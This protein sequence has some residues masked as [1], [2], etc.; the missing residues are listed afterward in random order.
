[1]K[2]IGLLATGD[3]II[4]GDILNTN[5]QNI[6]QSLF[7]N[8]MQIGLHMTASDIQ[9]DIEKSLIFLLKDH[10]AVILTGGL[11]PTSDD[12]TRFALASAI[13]QELIFS[14]ES[15][16]R[17]QQ[18]F[19]KIKLQYQPESN[20]QQCLFPEQAEIFANKNGT[21][22]ACYV[23]ANGKAIF[24]LP[25]PP[26]E[27]LPIFEECVIPKLQQLEFASGQFHRN[28]LLLGVSEGAIAESLDNI[29][30]DYDVS[31]GFRASMPY[32]EFKVHS[33]SMDEIERFYQQAK[34]VIDDKHVNKENY[35]ASL[36]L[37]K[38]LQ[39]NRFNIHIHDEATKG[40][41]LSH[42]LSP[43]TQPHLKASEHDAQHAFL[44]KGLDEIWQQSNVEQTLLHV[45]E[46]NTILANRG[47]RTMRLAFE[48][49]SQHI[50]NT[51]DKGK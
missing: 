1:M 12:R 50:L 32:V 29:A 42:I 22:D 2:T 7:S 14:D 13:Q 8:G 49:I 48:Y 24:M 11:G 16:Q 6:A 3:E 26:H 45:N 34:S 46:C 47:M 15:W 19:T 20:K 28:W 17:I 27:C 41:Y 35:P 10:D 43:E 51:I 37:C 31:T 25:G 23:N 9:T 30:K 44:I 21:A 18:R 5:T 40:L 38:Q 33:E 36:L 4:N 39:E